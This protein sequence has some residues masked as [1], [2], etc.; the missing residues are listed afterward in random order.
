MDIDSDIDAELARRA[1]I[2]KVLPVSEENTGLPSGPSPSPRPSPRPSPWPSPMP[3]PPPSGGIMEFLRHL[4]HLDSSSTSASQAK[5][6]RGD[7]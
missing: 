4:V 3:S 7:Q 2:R 5:A 1:K 6:L